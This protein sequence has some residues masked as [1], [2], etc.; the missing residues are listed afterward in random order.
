MS[1]KYLVLISLI[2]SLAY[3]QNGIIK[4]DASFTATLITSSDCVASVKIYKQRVTSKGVPLRQSIGTLYQQQPI[5]TKSY[6][7]FFPQGKNNLTLTFEFNSLP[8]DQPYFVIAEFTGPT[9]EKNIMGWYTDEKCSWLSYITLD[10]AH[11][12][13]HITIDAVGSVPPTKPQKIANGEIKFMKNVTVVH[14]LGDEKQRGFAHGY[15]LAQQIVDFFRFFNLH[16]DIGSCSLYTSKYVPMLE[17]SVSGPGGPFFFSDEML[18]E[19]DAIIEGMKANKNVDLYFPELGR[20]F[21][22]IELLAI[23]SYVE[24]EYLSSQGDDSDSSLRSACSQFA[25]W[26]SQT[27]QNSDLKGG[28]VG[29]RNMDGEIVCITTLM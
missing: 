16:S 27:V 23:N 13:K 20:N 21:S 18:T 4:G 12:Q 29:G 6:K 2:V 28:I 10:Q 5:A 19:I 14:L 7:Y 24:F 17:R 25:I 26:G 15:L 8:L 9:V 11:P 22:R 1:H 3:C